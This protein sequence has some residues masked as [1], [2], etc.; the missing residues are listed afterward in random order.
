MF[1]ELS[2]LV[3]VVWPVFAMEEKPLEGFWEK[4]LSVSVSV[5]I[6]FKGLYWHGKH[7]LTLPK[8]VR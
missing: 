8:Q 4:A 5:T 6:Q 3:G 2:V 1:A 7:V